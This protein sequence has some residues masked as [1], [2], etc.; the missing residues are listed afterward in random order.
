ML[1]EEVQR[2][3]EVQ[4]ALVHLREEHHMVDTGRLVAASTEVERQPVEHQQVELHQVDHPFVVVVLASMEV[5]HLQVGRQVVDHQEVE[6]RMASEHHMALEH[7]MEVVPC[8][9]EVPSL[10][11]PMEE[12]GQKPFY[13]HHHHL[14]AT[15]EAPCDSLSK[16]RHHL[17]HQWQHLHPILP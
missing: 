1:I 10:L 14:A 16:L 3:E 9:L 4:E 17:V 12:V 11:Q 7:P 15:V 6:H 5:G 13:H 2:Q 8:R